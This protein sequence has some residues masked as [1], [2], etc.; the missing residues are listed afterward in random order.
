VDLD[1]EDFEIVDMLKSN[2]KVIWAKEG[3]NIYFQY[4]AKFEIS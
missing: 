2:P 1:G 3:D 4:K